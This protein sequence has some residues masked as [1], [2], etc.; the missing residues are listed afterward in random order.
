M[1]H[2]VIN[3]EK[4]EPTLI[5]IG[6]PTA[7][8]KTALSIQLAQYFGA[9]IISADARQFFKEME[10]G[11]AKPSKTE[12]SAVKHHFINCKSITETYSSGDFERDVDAFLENYFKSK[13]VAI[14]CGG[15]GL[16]IQAVLHGLDTMP[17][18]PLHI[19]ENLMARLET[20]GLEILKNELL[21]LEPKIG[22]NI[23]LQNP[24]RV[25][26][27]LEVNIHTGQN[28]GE[29][30]KANS[31]KLPFNVIK[32][33]L[34][35]PREQLYE[36]INARVDAM[37]LL[38]L[39]DE[40]KNLVEYQGLNSLKTV[41]YSEI[42]SFLNND[43]SQERAVELIKQNTRRYAKRQL[44]WFKNKDTFTWFGP[45]EFEE[46]R[47]FCDASMVEN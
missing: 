30:R 44:T 43:I 1:S 40:V 14:L 23:D 38:G 25:V 36:G 47:A 29:L 15:S 20:E 22:E 19:R 35:L 26:R 4:K 16:Y 39:V 11:T 13:N 6:G 8:G 21:E 42:L 5:V 3:L 41:G 27:A 33:G 34:E 7:V 24:Q 17:I 2:A 12:L 18:T 28:F 31:K 9:E 10:I 37:M 46:I 32:I 45:E